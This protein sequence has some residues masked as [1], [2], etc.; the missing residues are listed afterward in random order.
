MKKK[1][2]ENLRPLGDILL[3]IEPLLLEMVDRHDLQHG[4]VYGLLRQYLEIHL[5][6]HKEE[7]ADNTRPI[8]Y[9]GHKDGLK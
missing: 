6:N 4:D 2:N 7:F 1:K 3:E 8:F 5:P 9:Y